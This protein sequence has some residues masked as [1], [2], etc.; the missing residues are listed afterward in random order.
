LADL[1]KH[2]SP[3]ADESDIHSFPHIEPALRYATGFPDPCLITGS[4]FF[5]GEVLA[6]RAG[7][8]AETRPGTQ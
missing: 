1:K 7:N 8:T 5:A 3:F 6:W 2:L 4:L